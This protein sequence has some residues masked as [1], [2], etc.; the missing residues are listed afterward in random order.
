MQHVICIYLYIS[1]YWFLVYID[2]FVCLYRKINKYVYVYI[3]MRLLML[4]ML[5]VD[6][7]IYRHIHWNN[8]LPV[9]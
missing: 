3:Y 5:H 7:A 1:V 8:W 2:V 9:C 4:C 6:I